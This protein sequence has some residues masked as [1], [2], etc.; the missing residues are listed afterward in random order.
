MSEVNLGLRRALAHLD[1]AASALASMQQQRPT[2]FDR[3]NEVALDSV[4]VRKII[5]Q[6]DMIAEEIDAQ[7]TLAEKICEAEDAHALRVLE[8]TAQLLA[9]R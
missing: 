1:K 8:E 3:L 4:E 2:R 6:M 9:Q 5:L 7:A